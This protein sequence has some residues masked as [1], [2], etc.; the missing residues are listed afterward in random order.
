MQL[1]EGDAT[2]AGACQ[3]RV[4]LLG[5]PEFDD[6]ASLGF[7]GHLEVVAGFRNALQAEHFNRSRRR[8]ILGSAP[9][10]VEHG[11]HFPEDGAADEEVAGA[12]RAVLYEHGGD[13][14]A[15]PVDTRFKHSAAC[16]S[17]GIGAQVAQLR[18]EEQYL[19]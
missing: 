8:S 18:D 4:A 19:E 7:V 6:V 17:I 1:I 3:R 10:I 12:E 16:G 9:V 14:A 2:A 11:A 5:L 13:G 15:A